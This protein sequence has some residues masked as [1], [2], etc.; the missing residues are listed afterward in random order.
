[1]RTIISLC[2]FLLITINVFAQATLSRLENKADFEKLSGMP[3]SEKYGQ[4]SSVKV[5]YDYVGKKLYFLNSKNY[6][7]HYD[8]CKEQDFER[9]DLDYFNRHNYSN[10]PDRDYLLGNIN[11]FHTEDKYTLEISSSDMMLLPLIY[12]FYHQIIENSFIG[13][14]LLFE[15][16]NPRLLNEKAKISDSIAVILPSEIY[17]NLSFQ[18]VSKQ[19]KIGTLKFIKSIDEELNNIFP[20]DIIVIAHTPIFIPPVSGVIVTEFQTPLSHLSILGKNRK[21]PICAYK[22]AFS[23]STLRTYENK[24]ILLTVSSDTFFINQ[25]NKNNIESANQESISLHSDLTVRNLVDVEDLN[26]KSISYAGNKA[27]NFGIL[28]KISKKASFKVPESA[29]AIPFSY[30]DD[31]L[32][33]SKAAELIQKMLNSEEIRFNR[34][35]LADYL[36]Q[37]QFVIINTPIDSILIQEVNAKVKSLGSYTNMRFRSSTNAEDA[38]GFSGAGL[39]TSETGILNSKKKS[40]E[41]AIKKVWASLWTYEAFTER[42]FFNIAHEEVYMGILVHRSFPSEEVNGVAITKN[43]YRAGNY[44]FVINAQVGDES[45]AKPKNGSIC[46]QF[47]CYPDNANELYSNKKDIDIITISNLNDGKLVMTVD[48]IQNLANQLEVIKSYVS[49][50]YYQR[51]DYLDL[52]LDIEFKLDGETRILYIKQVRYFND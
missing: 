20:D 3:L 23:D 9:Y 41:M 32:K 40:F 47:I 12:L 6:K 52:G 29:F 5:V 46:D 13:D 38:E 11:Y 18:A 21:I 51:K 49:S 39:Y 43:L 4:V 27:S 22:Y 44:G 19:R 42:E 30:Y 16:N 7:F 45:V 50:H 8:F 36:E 37:I 24:K 33:R 15:L 10:E 28:Y 31:H 1:M 14:K 35:S 26:K 17:Q 25:T 34:D 2:L 48:E